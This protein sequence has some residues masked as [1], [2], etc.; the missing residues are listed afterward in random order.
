MV[1]DATYYNTQYSLY[2][3]NFFWDLITEGGKKPVSPRTANEN[4]IIYHIST[5][6]HWLPGGSGTK[7]YLVIIAAQANYLFLKI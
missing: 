6:L 3:I 4:Y 7:Y 2:V 1:E 5:F